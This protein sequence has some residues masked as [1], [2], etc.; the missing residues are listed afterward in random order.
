MTRIW[1]AGSSVLYQTKCEH[2]SKASLCRFGSACL[3]ESTGTK[4]GTGGAGNGQ[5]LCRHFRTGK[6]SIDHL[7]SKGGK[8]RFPQ[9]SLPGGQLWWGRGS[10]KSVWWGDQATLRSSN[11]GPLQGGL[12]RESSQSM[13]VGALS[14]VLESCLCHSRVWW[15][16]WASV[17]P[18]VKWSSVIR[19]KLFWD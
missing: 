4:V 15:K 3:P 7:G 16:L 1:N 6:N 13:G 19:P 11:A 14:P 12:S 18:S 5:K 10:Q 8:R 9:L 17:F 2:F